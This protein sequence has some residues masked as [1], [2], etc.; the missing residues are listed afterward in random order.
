MQIT[1]TKLKDH[2]TWAQ[3]EQARHANQ[4]RQPHPDY[5][6][7]DKVYINAKEFAPERPSRSL[8]LKNV[9]PWEIIRTIENKAYELAIPQQLKDAGLTPISNPW[10]LHLAPNNP[11]PGQVLPPNPP[12]LIVGDEL[13]EGARVLTCHRRIGGSRLCI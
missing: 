2:L 8:G 9:R 6:V 12:I 1:K 11:F 13:T 3:E 7:G 5:K 4:G 10:K